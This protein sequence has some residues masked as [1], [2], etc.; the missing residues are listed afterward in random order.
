MSDKVK[1]QIKRLPNGEGMPFPKYETEHSAGM[2][3]QA[4]IP[5]GEQMLL[6]PGA[7]DLVPTGIAI[8]LPDKYEAQIRPRS[9][10]ALKNGITVP[11]APGTIDAD[12]R[13]EIKIILQ[14]LGTED[15][16]I[17]RGMRIAQM[18]IAP[19]V[20][21]VWEEVEDLSQTTRGEGGFG[22][23]GV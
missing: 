20:Q 21:S 9:G 2:D 12:Y 23:T 17:E 13:G 10:L 1:V 3:L 16:V 6:K 22:S 8:G 5:E 11:N 4:A 19:V 18:I 15:F 7:I 14:N